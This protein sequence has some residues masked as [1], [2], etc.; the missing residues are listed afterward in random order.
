MSQVSTFHTSDGVEIAYRDT[1]GEGV[2]LVLLHGW[3]CN[4][5]LFRAQVDGLRES[6][7]VITM[8]LRGHGR[9][10]VPAFGHR[11]SRLAADVREL[12]SVLDI[13]YVD[14]LGWSMG[15]SVWFSFIDLFGQSAIRRLI[16][17]DEPSLLLDVPWMSAR[18]DVS[19]GVLFDSATV[20]GIVQAMDSENAAAVVS[21]MFTGSFAGDVDADVR[22]EVL[23]AMQSTSATEAGRLLFDHAN[24]DWTDVVQRITSP[25]LVVGCEGSHI[26]PEGLRAMT[27]LMP[28]AHTVVLAPP[29]A[30]SHFPFLENPDAFN[31]LISTF[32]DGSMSVPVPKVCPS[33]DSTAIGRELQSARGG[34]G[35]ASRGGPGSGDRRSSTR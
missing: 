27:A 15:A 3:L 25:T 6:R 20:R 34:A 28:D 13:D 23:S 18:G 24:Q 14:A 19:A 16:V 17:V 7:R 8:D 22:S 35:S 33:D 5:D 21:Q 32:L 4:Q 10:E 2:P 12:L 9:S 29:V 30:S 1:G 31:Q 26:D 11:I